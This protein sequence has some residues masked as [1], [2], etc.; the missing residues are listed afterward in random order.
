MIIKT[1]YGDEVKSKF[2]RGDKVYV[3][4]TLY[5]PISCYNRTIK[6][7]GQICGIRGTAN[8]IRTFFTYTV[9]PTDDNEE[10]MGKDM[11]IMEEDIE[12]REDE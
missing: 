9:V 12:L 8:R 11:I 2:N 6:V 3:Y 5:G 1:V 4:I 10:M 7:P